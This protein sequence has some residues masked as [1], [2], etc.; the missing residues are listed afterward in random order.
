MRAKVRPGF[1][2]GGEAF[3]HHRDVEQHWFATLA[4][5]EPAKPGR[6]HARRTEQLGGCAKV[7]Q[8]IGL[9]GQAQGDADF[10]VGNRRVIRRDRRIELALVV[11]R[12]SFHCRLQ[13]PI[14]KSIS[15][16]ARSRQADG[17]TRHVS[18]FS[19]FAGQRGPGP[20]VVQFH[21]RQCKGPP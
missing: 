2:R 19:E 5:G 9:L 20:L 17:Q 15:R 11:R 8:T 1:Q 3:R 14:E 10:F 6:I 4:D 7:V 18:G 12:A 21:R 13:E 16:P